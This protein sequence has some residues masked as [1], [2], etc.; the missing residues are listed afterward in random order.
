MIDTVTNRLDTFK[1]NKDRI[2]TTIT[3]YP[4]DRQQWT[5]VNPELA[6]KIF[7]L[8]DTEVSEG[9]F[10]KLNLIPKE[11]DDTA[12]EYDAYYGDSSPLVPAFVM[13]KKP[14]MIANYERQTETGQKGL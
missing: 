14:V 4:Y 7:D 6:E 10:D 5:N 3:L 12:L 1:E 9:T 13:Q 8:I 2:R 11:A